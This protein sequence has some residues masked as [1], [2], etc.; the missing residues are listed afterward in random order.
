MKIEKNSFESKLERMLKKFTFYAGIHCVWFGFLAYGPEYCGE[1]P[2]QKIERNINQELVQWAEYEDSIS[3]TV[4][5]GDDKI[6]FGGYDKDKDG[7]FELVII[8]AM[9]SERTFVNKALK[10]YRYN[11]YYSA[12]NYDLPDLRARSDTRE[13]AEAMKEDVY[14]YRNEL[15][16]LNDYFWYEMVL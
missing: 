11:L 1:K 8:G 2:L 7:F 4:F 10:S 13:I 6:R 3:L 16:D 15:H 9:D 5:N 12:H 14:Y